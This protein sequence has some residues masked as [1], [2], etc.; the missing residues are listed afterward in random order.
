MFGKW[1]NVTSMDKLG[2]DNVLNGLAPDASP[3]DYL[4]TNISDKIKKENLEFIY[5]AKIYYDVVYKTNP[6]EW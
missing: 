1:S 4:K 3:L 5:K 6:N 2:R